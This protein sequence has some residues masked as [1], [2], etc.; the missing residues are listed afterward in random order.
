[1][2]Y[3]K[4]D[5]ARLSADYTNIS[6][7]PTDPTTVYVT[8]RKPGGTTTTYTYGGGQVLKDSTGRYRCDVSL[9]ESGVWQYKWFGTGALVVAEEGQFTVRTTVF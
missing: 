1:M 7:V 3:D 9:D 8:V 4:G 6:G 5:H 2:A